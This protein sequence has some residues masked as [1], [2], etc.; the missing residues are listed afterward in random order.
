M[1]LKTPILSV[2][3][4]VVPDIE[5]L[6]R[7]WET[8]PMYRSVSFE[9]FMARNSMGRDQYNL[10]QLARSLDA[11]ARTSTN[12]PP[13]ATKIAAAGIVMSLPAADGTHM[14]VQRAY[15]GENEARIIE[16]FSRIFMSP[17]DG[18]DM[19]APPF[20]L[21]PRTMKYPTLVTDGAGDPDGTLVARA[22]RYAYAEHTTPDDQGNRHFISSFLREWYDDS[23]KW[24]QNRPNYR[25]KYNPYVV[26]AAAIFAND[27]W[28]GSVDLAGQSFGLDASNRPSRPS[29]LKEDASEKERNDA[30]AM[31]ALSALWRARRSMELYCIQTDIV[32]GTDYMQTLLPS[33][34]SVPLS[35]DAVPDTIKKL[36]ERYA[37]DAAAGRKSVNIAVLRHG[38]PLS[39]E[40]LS[41]ISRGG[42]FVS[43]KENDEAKQNNRSEPS[44]FERFLTGPKQEGSEEIP[45]LGS[46]RDPSF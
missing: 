2:A 12:Y 15:H 1:Y 35:P 6:R 37:E 14:T 44:E 39:A 4:E 29:K 38:D 43:P 42:H 36:K 10:S 21:S 23:D 8:S 40:E 17:I 26:N 7:H 5:M 19:A 9:R 46:D 32:R 30:G 28:S 20:A 11:D 41:I 34:T 18:I 3:L 13:V 16:A 25:M 33:L 45:L 27:R 24:S 22:M 31:L